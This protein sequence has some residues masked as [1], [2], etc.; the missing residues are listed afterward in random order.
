MKIHYQTI[1]KWTRNFSNGRAAKAICF[2]HIDT[3][4]TFFNAPKI[5]Y[6]TRFWMGLRG[7]YQ[8]PLIESTVLLWGNF[9]RTF[10]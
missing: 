4:S 8:D 7:H 3:Q 10:Y 2:S 5:E 1:Q 6:T 9:N